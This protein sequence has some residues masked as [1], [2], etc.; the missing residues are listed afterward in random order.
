MKKIKVIFNQ[1][2]MISTA[3]LFGLGIQAFI[4]HLQGKEA[5]I[6]WPWYIPFSII[7]AGFLCALP[8]W[9]LLEDDCSTRWY[10]LCK[11][12]HFMVLWG[13][14]SLCGLLFQWYTG[15]KEYIS[16][17]VMYVII[18]GFV[19]IATRWLVKRDEIRINEAIREIQDEE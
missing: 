11:V 17:M 7:I 1:T 5:M 10:R 19:W 6:E 3:M 4:R 16:V 8:T 15:I 14:V 9:F 12:V 13:I 2:L 18:Y